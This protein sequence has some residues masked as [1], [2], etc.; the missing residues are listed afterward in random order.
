MDAK[1]RVAEAIARRVADGQVLGVGTGS[2]VDLALDALAVRARDDGLRFRAFTTSRQSAL[3]CFEAGAD[4][5]DRTL[6]SRVP[7]DWGFDGADEVEVT[8]T[9]FRLIKGGGAAL[10][11]EKK[12]AVHC[13][14]WVVIVDES[15]IVSRLGARAPVPIDVDPD[16]QGYVERKLRELSAVE[17]HLRDG[18]PGKDGELRTEQNNLILDVRFEAIPEDAEKTIKAI[19]GVIES[20]L[21]FSQATEVLVAGSS[22]VVSYI[23]RYGKV[24][25]KIPC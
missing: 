9:D 21:F 7:I 18:E 1:H 17:I 5:L 25:R 11:P 16:M 10:Y 23:K 22:G 14:D 19:T 13:P 20:G 12:V 3:R 6:L 2:T 24:E 4:V 15:K 8:E